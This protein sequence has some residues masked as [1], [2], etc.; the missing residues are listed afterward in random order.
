MLLSTSPGFVKGARA[1]VGVRPER[2]GFDGPGDNRVAGVLED[3]VFLGDR[4]E[5][6][7]EAIDGEL[8]VTAVGP[9]ATT[10]RRLP[11]GL[12]GTVSADGRVWLQ[13]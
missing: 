3:R 7:V 4:S 8:R 12:R 5:W 2:L 13:P 6:R 11:L 1:W 9:R 10:L